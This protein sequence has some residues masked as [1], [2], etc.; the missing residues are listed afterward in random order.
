MTC[1]DQSS[2]CTYEEC[3]IHMLYIMCMRYMHV[4]SS[5]PHFSRSRLIVRRCLYH[6]A[7]HPCPTCPPTFLGATTVLPSPLTHPIAMGSPPHTPLRATST[8]PAQLGV[9]LQRGKPA[10]WLRLPCRAAGPLWKSCDRMGPGKFLFSSWCHFFITEFVLSGVEERVA[11]ARGRISLP[12]VVFLS[13]L[14]LC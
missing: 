3:T 14:H 6:I 4:L 9:C 8:V 12:I 10:T 5:L 7:S 1:V 13:S 2:T 11:N